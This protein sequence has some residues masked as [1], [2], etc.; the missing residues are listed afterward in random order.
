M[1]SS[2]TRARII[3]THLQLATSQEGSM[4][5]AEYM[6]KMWSLGDEMSGKTP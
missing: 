4:T 3:N 5:I 1:F 2:Q 6:N